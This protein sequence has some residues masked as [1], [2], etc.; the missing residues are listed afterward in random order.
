MIKHNFRE[1]TIW[2][3][4][5][6]IAKTCYELAATFP[7]SEKFGL[8]SQLN[9]A[10]VSIPSNIAEGS[11]RSTNK[12]FAYF[13][14]ISLSSSYEVETQLLL[15]KSIYEVDTDQIIIQL[16]NL[17]RMMYGFKK[18]LKLETK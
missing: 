17:Q 11:G 1:L 5:M 8:I 9:R 18:S 12:E 7:E 10:V 4:A 15:M 2:K 3:E 16:N 13:L 6:S 14:N